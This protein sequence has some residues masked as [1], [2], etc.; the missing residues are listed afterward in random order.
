[1]YMYIYLVCVIRWGKL[2]LTGLKFCNVHMPAYVYATGT[3]TA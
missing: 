3:L 2:P 1:M